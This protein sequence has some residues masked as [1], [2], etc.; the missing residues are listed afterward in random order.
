MKKAYAFS[1]LAGMF[2][3]GCQTTS[4]IDPHYKGDRA[5]PIASIRSVTLEKITSTKEFMKTGDSLYHQGYCMLGYALFTGLQEGPNEIKKFAASVGADCILSQVALVGTTTQSYM[6]LD[7]YTPGRTVT[8]YGSATA[9]GTGT[10]T[11]SLTT[12]YGPMSYNS[13]TTGTAYGTGSSTTYIPAQSTY[14]PRY[15]EVPITRQAY[16]FW[17]SPQG[18]LRNLRE[19]WGKLNS[20]KPANQQASEEAMKMFAMHF[21]QAWNLVLPKDLRPIAEVKELST[22]EKKKF[23]ESWVA[24]RETSKKLNELD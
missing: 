24:G 18:Y 11:G 8:T 5:K 1:I 6:G 21:A 20:A 19:E 16:A 3:A 12:P 7:S 23:R 14:S 13:Q 2:L 15:Y 22:E 9:Y 10:S 17:L 4:N